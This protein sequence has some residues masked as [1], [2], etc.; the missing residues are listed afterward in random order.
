MSSD[1]NFERLILSN[2][3]NM[4][5]LLDNNFKIVY[6]NDNAK[7]IFKTLKIDIPFI[8]LFGNDKIEAMRLLNFLTLNEINYN[9]GYLFYFNERYLNINIKKL[10]PHIIFWIVVILKMSI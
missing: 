4:E 3:S 2:M 5:I 8:K 10:I 1:I 9:P 6:F 7:N